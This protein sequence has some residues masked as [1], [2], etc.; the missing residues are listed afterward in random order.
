MFADSHRNVQLPQVVYHKQLAV[1]YYHD[2]NLEEAHIPASVEVAN[3][4][5]KTLRFLHP[6]CHEIQASVCAINTGIK[7]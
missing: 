7:S 4:A 5:R 1:L 2:S 6:F 3:V